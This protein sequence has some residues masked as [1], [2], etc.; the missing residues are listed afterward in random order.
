M[1]HPASSES[2]AA[3]P[4]PPRSLPCSPCSSPSA[5]PRGRSPRATAWHRSAAP[6]HRHHESAR[7]PRDHSCARRCSS[8]IG[9]W[10]STNCSACAGNPGKAG[11]TRRPARLCPDDP[12]ECATAAPH[13]RVP[14]W[15]V[16]TFRCRV[17][18]GTK[19]ATPGGSRSRL[20]RCAHPRYRVS[21]PEKSPVRAE[22]ET[23]PLSRARASERV[24]VSSGAMPLNEL[25]ASAGVT[26]EPVSLLHP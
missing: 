10:P 9:R 15:V 8:R 24:G 6:H 11:R 19:Y 25:R 4:A 7:L 5:A 3:A 21:R 14:R 23:C 13:G 17:P 18:S 22:M 26:S 2:R 20:S 1:S 16:P 12:A